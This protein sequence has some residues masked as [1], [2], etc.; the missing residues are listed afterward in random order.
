MLALADGRHWQLRA[1]EL[2]DPSCPKSRPRGDTG[3]L[4]WAPRLVS[5]RG[6]GNGALCGGRRCWLSLPPW[7]VLL[8][9]Y[10]GVGQV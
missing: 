8:G 4:G 1:A 2:V 7:E 9:V 10:G 3:T 5:A 6:R